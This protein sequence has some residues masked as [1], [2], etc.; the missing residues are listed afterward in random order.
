MLIP[1]PALGSGKLDTPCDRMQSANRT[2][3]ANFAFDPPL[4]DLPDEPQAATTTVQLRATR[5]S[6]SWRRWLPRMSLEIA[7]RI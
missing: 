1:P 5:A 3:A 2:P 6:G 7:V 4:L